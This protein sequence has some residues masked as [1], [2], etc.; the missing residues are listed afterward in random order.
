MSKF[1]MWLHFALGFVNIG[2]AFKL[3]SF[4]S[5]KIA[6]FNF[7]A[8]VFTLARAIATAILLR[9]STP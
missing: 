8:G 9:R 7:A 1:T 5:Y 4:G 2:M 6:A 3:A